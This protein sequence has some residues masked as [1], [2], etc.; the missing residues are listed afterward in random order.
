MITELHPTSFGNFKAWAM[1]NSNDD[2]WATLI[3]SDDFDTEL[4]LTL[5]ISI[6]SYTQLWL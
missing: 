5:T 4:Y 1:L 3:Y 6:L 2:S